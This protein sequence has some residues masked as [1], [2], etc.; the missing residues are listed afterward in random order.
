MLATDQQIWIVDKQFWM[1][2]TKIKIFIQKQK[3]LLY[4][5]LENVFKKSWKFCY[6]LFLFSLSVCPLSL[7][8]QIPLFWWWK[9]V[10]N[11]PGR[12]QPIVK[13]SKP[14][15]PPTSSTLTN[16]ISICISTPSS[17]P[18]NSV[19]KHFQLSKNRDESNFCSISTF[20][21]IFSVGVNQ[22]GEKLLSIGWGENWHCSLMW[23][24]PNEA[25]PLDPNDIH[26]LDDF[27]AIQSYPTNPKCSHLLSIKKFLLLKTP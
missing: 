5:L 2:A 9:K 7:R 12:S 20:C 22:S 24:S 10:G 15:F 25:R 11:S 27:L 26:H 21:L 19:N 16:S 13:I 3:T 8:W 18:K 23:T 4:N 17:F 14:Q 6:F 1:K